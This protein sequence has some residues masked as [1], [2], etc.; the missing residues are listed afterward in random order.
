MEHRKK[1]N[2]KGSDVTQDIDM[3]DK[4]KTV[5]GMI[6]KWE[7]QINS[8]NSFCCIDRWNSFGEKWLLVYFVCTRVWTKY[9]YLNDCAFVTTVATV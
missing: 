3:M 9:F 8:Q 7:K 6:E 4:E 1:I 5:E 2:V